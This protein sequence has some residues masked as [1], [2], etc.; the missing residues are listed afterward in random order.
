RDRVTI[1]VE[2]QERHFELIDTGGLGL[3]DDHLLKEHIEAQ[4]EVAIQA[5][6]LILFVVDAKE[7]L[8][9]MDEMVARRLRRLTA[10]VLL[11][12]NKVESQWEEHSVSDWF[13][14]G[15]GD[16]IPVSANEGFGISDLLDTV[17]ANLPE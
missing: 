16:P 2:W 12:V 1:E 8:V 13:K 4:I 5:S 10:K 17:V 9:P 6:D 15:F 7:G 11:V 14:L 3:V